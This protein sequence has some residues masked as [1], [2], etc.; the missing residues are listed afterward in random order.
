M[1][2]Q[3]KQSLSALRPQYTTSQGS[4][5]PRWVRVVVYWVG[6]IMLLYMIGAVLD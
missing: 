6:G 1:S 5:E 3:G 2:E 4:K